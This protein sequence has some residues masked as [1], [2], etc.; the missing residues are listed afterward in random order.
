MINGGNPEILKDSP[1]KSRK[2]ANSLPPMPKPIGKV[3]RI[4]YVTNPVKWRCQ[5]CTFLNDV[6]N[7]VCQTCQSFKGEKKKGKK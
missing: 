4:G 7:T 1:I 2:P 3:V 5:I 6:S